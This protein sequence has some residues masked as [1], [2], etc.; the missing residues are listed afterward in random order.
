MGQNAKFEWNNSHFLHFQAKCKKEIT[1]T[2]VLEGKGQKYDV[3]CVL[4]FHNY[5][6]RNNTDPE[7]VSK[8]KIKMIIDNFTPKM[9]KIWAKLCTILLFLEIQALIYPELSQRPMDLMY[10]F[11][12]LHIF[13]SVFMVLFWKDSAFLFFLR[14]RQP[15]SVHYVPNILT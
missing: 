11:V 8:N 14:L 2:K 13:I 1:E 7:Q 3:I 9:A 5:R 15:L 10:R 4:N 12:I 6:K